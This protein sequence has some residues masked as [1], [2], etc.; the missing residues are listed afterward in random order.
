MVDVPRSDP[1]YCAGFRYFLSNGILVTAIDVLRLAINLVLSD[2]A[3]ILPGEDRAGALCSSSAFAHGN[4]PLDTC[5]DLPLPLLSS[6][7]K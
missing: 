2:R 1:C 3:A 4:Y 6:V 7:K 5:I